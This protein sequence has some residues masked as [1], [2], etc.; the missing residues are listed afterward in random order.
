MSEKKELIEIFNEQGAPTGEYKDRKEVH[1][2]GLWHRTIHLWI[3]NS[4]GELLLQ[5]RSKTKD[6]NPNLWDISVAGHIEKGQS[7]IEAALRETKEEIGLVC[8]AEELEFL[9][10]VQNIFIDPHTA[11]QDH[12]FQ[13]VYILKADLDI[14]KLKCEVNEVQ[15]LAWVHWSDLEKSYIQGDAKLVTHPEEYPLL[16]NR[17]SLELE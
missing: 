13:D 16:F 17:L 15:A 12:E 11:V 14:S 5:Q 10:E 3:L 1:A 9:F 7:S 4:K 8:K 6:T 2:M